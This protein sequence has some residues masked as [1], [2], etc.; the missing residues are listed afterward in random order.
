MMS[1]H[2]AAVTGSTTLMGPA[3]AAPR[4]APPFPV[5]ILFDAYVVMFGAP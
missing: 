5:E 4:V 3:Q 2:D 1:M